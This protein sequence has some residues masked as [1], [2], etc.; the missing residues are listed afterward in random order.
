MHKIDKHKNGDDMKN[1]VMPI[2]VPNGLIFSLLVLSFVY[3][4]VAYY[5]PTKVIINELNLSCLS[6]K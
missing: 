3:S 4:Q 1:T 6:G 5:N 2:N